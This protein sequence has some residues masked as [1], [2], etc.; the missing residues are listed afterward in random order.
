MSRAAV[1]V[2]PYTVVQHRGLSNLGTLGLL[3]DFKADGIAY[4]PISQSNSYCG[5]HSGGDSLLH[6]LS[7]SAACAMCNGRLPRKNCSA[8]RRCTLIASG[9]TYT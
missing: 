6:A 3:K 5:R 7:I 1:F 4:S 8:S 2:G 9:F